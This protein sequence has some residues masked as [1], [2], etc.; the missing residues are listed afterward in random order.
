MCASLIVRKHKWCRSRMFVVVELIQFTS[1]LSLVKMTRPGLRLWIAVGALLVAVVAVVRVTETGP[2]V[3]VRWAREVT[4]P[5]RLEL[6]RQY[7]LLNGSH[8]EGAEWRY[9]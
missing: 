2:R 7:A 1:Q 3:T 4:E 6:E 8:G 5:A 9:E